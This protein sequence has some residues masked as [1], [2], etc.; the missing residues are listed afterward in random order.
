MK[1]SYMKMEIDLIRRVI[2]LMMLR[3]LE[4]GRSKKDVF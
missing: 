2:I 4:S 3:E 1:E